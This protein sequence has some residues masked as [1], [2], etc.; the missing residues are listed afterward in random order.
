MPVDA[1]SPPTLWTHLTSRKEGSPIVE[2]R[3]F[4]DFSF[5]FFW[6]VHYTIENIFKHKDQIFYAFVYYN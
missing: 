2:G 4:V 5:N 6:D 3:I 1:D